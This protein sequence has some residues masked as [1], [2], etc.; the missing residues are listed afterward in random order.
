MRGSSKW[1]EE[2]SR[3]KKKQEDRRRKLREKHDNIYNEALAKQDADDLD[4]AELLLL[5]CK[6]LQKEYPDLLKGWKDAPIR[7]IYLYAR[8]EDPA[9]G[10][11]YLD[12]EFDRPQHYHIMAYQNE[13]ERPDVAECI[14]RHTLDRFPNDASTYKSLALL[15]ARVGRTQDAI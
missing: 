11:A 9:D 10:L 12:E 8:R 1:N 13:H 7:L 6:Q 5:E 14:Y 2:Q 15:L 4:A 3:V